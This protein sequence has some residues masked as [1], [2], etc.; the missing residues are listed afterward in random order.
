[1]SITDGAVLAVAFLVALVVSMTKQTE[2]IG[3]E[4]PQ[5]QRFS[6]P[7]PLRVYRGRDRVL[8]PPPNWV[9]PPLLAP[10]LLIKDGSRPL[11]PEIQRELLKMRI[12]GHEDQEGEVVSIKSIQPSL[13]L[14]KERTPSPEI[15]CPDGD[16]GSDEGGDE[17]CLRSNPESWERFPDEVE[18][19]RLEA[20]ELKT[21]IE[22]MSTNGTE[23][24]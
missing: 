4:I 20:Q 9:P 3:P 7:S 13:L 5:I 15:F 23:R 1:M 12:S 14:T 8:P 2:R 22:R 6:P 17:G 19:I 18:A 10:E 21:Q 24:P 11:T 16:G